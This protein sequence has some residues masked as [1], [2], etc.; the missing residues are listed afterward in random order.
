MDQSTC[1][2]LLADGLGSNPGRD[3]SF[4]SVG[5]M[6]GMLLRLISL[7]GTSGLPVSS[8]TVTGAT[9]EVTTL[10]WD[11]NVHII[12]FCGAECGPH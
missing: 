11:R 12:T 6:A 10:W 7:P 1:W 5:L 2:A 8:L 4:Q 3:L 9:S